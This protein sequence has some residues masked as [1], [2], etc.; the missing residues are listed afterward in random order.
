MDSCRLFDLPT[1]G[2][3]SHLEVVWLFGAVEETIRWNSEFTTE[4]DRWQDVQESHSHSRESFAC[5]FAVD[6][7]KFE[8]Q[9]L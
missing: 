5:L 7:A 6:R 9:W 2:Q 1:T 8:D 4:N 3:S